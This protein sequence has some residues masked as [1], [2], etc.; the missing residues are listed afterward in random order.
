MWL[1][2][3]TSFLTDKRQGGRDRERGDKDKREK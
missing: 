1:A 3:I 2:N